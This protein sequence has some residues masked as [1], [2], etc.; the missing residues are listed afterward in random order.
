MV[1]NLPG[2]PGKANK[3]KK[4]R[5]F[6]V[7]KLLL[8]S[9]NFGHFDSLLSMIWGHHWIENSRKWGGF[10]GSQGPAIGSQASFKILSATAVKLHFTRKSEEFLQCRSKFWNLLGNLS[11]ALEIRS[12]PPFSTI[13][14]PV[15][16]SN[17]W[18]ERIKVTK[19]FWQ[20]RRGGSKIFGHSDSLLGPWESQYPPIFDYSLSSGGLKSLIWANE[21]DQKKL[22]WQN[23]FDRKK[24]VVFL[25][26]WVPLGCPR[27]TQKIKKKTTFFRSKNL[28][29]SKIVGHFDSL[30]SMI[31]G[32]HWIENS[33]KW[34]G[35]C[36]SQGPAIG[37]QASFKILSGTAVKP[38]FTS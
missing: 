9:K 34:G 26:C 21:N 28:V 20:D 18:Y 4:N 16:A 32:H 27:G 35:F 2:A 25:I 36:R 1:R 11:Q 5:F 8:M 17:H 33:R 3:S 31:W 19:N 38:H 24:V 22:T 29:M 7:K 37:S 12:T 30:I 23:L 15:V 14:Y 10:W 13:L 6:F